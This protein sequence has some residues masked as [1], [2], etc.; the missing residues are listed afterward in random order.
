MSSGNFHLVGRVRVHWRTKLWLGCLLTIIF[1]AGYFGIEYH[2]VRSPVSLG[3]TTI[4]R[5][6]P[7]S[8]EWV[9]VYQSIYLLLPAAWLCETTDE[10]KRYAIGFA[11]LIFAGFSCFLIWPVAGP[12]PE[13]ISND[14]MYRV[15]VRYDTT[16][17][18]FPSLHMAL[19]AYSAC[20]VVAVTSGSTRR[21]LTVLLPVWVALIGYATLATKQ[22]YLV[23]LPPGILLGWLAQHVAWKRRRVKAGSPAYAAKRVA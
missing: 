15:L 3:L 23:D 7:F 10:L 8:T 18:S 6:V 21:L 9:W 13:Q 22:H 11:I 4:D 19:A 1:C 12:R 16:L 14:P 17:N 2:P 20:I 5:S